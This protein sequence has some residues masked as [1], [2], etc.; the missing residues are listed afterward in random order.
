LR[1]DVVI[2]EFISGEGFDSVEALRRARMLL[3]AN[4]LTRPG[5]QRMADEKL[6]AARELL[7]SALLRLC[8]NAECAR[9]TTAL[10]GRAREVVTVSASGCE[11]CGG[12]NNRRAAT[13][14]AQ[15]LFSNQIE[16]VLVVGGMRVQHAELEALVQEVT[17]RL[18]TPTP[19]KTPEFRFVD[20]VR[21]SHSKRQAAPNLEWAQLLVI[22][23]ATPLPHKVSELYTVDPPSHVRVVKMARRSLDALCREVIR[24][25]E[26]SASEG[27]VAPADA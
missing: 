18:T 2:D 16:R 25:F 5:K 11:I 14:L 12:S 1:R 6:S 20:G 23:G 10:T 17:S 3:E 9:L 13:A 19:R 24:S 4:G 22:W 27:S 15:C 8:D 21:G 7:T 26:P